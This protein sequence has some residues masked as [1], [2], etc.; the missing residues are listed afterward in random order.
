MV[1]AA[2]P[3]GDQLALWS[4]APLVGL[5]LAVSLLELTAQRWWSSLA[6]KAIVAGLAA[7]LAGVHLVAGHGSA[8]GRALLH[9]L[10]DYTSFLVL[11]TAL[12]V[13]AGG[14]EVK[15][16]LSGTPLANTAMLAIGAV[17]A[18]LIGTTGAAMVLIR[19]Y[20]RANARRTRKAHLVVFFILVV[21]N[22]GGLLTPLGDPPLYLGFLKGVPFGWTLNLWLPWLFVNGLVLFV[23]NLVDQFLVNREERAK[24][25]EALLDE[26][27]EHERLR[28]LGLRNLAFLAGVVAV[29]L[30]RGSGVGTA[31]QPWPFGIQEVLLG[32]LAVG[33]YMLTPRGVHERNHFSFR[34]M[35]AV[36]VVF[37]GIFVAMTSPLLL[38]N[39]RSEQFGLS[40]SWH[41]FWASG[42]LSAVLDNAPTYLSL[43]AVAAGQAGLSSHDPLYLAALLG[44]D[45]GA[46]LLTA[47]SCG[48]VFMG[49]LTYIGNGP[50]LM[51]KEMAEHRG[52]RM[53]NFFAYTA[54]ATLVMVPIFVAATAIFFPPGAGP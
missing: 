38:L 26:L 36:A 21:A 49:C 3:L 7:G 47:I 11:L 28:V 34:P 2:Q 51:V 46:A 50:N 4:A 17:L 15:G 37:F 31:G 12:F 1:L 5:L 14:I 20:L 27:L 23:F 33:S 10:A 30:A 8:G 39:A 13:V 48:A 54:V 41:F 9:S 24:R 35:A 43:T 6:N 45:G 29:T 40:A 42:G 18:N 52:I 19:P 32:C 22:A 25:D 16:S 44:A 53:P